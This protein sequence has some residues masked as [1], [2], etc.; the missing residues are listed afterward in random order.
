[1]NTKFKFTNKIIS[2]LCARLQQFIVI[3]YSSL[4]T[5]VPQYKG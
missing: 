3:T 2:S 5:C 1:M 4:S